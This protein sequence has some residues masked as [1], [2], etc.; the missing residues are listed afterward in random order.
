MFLT[1]SSKCKIIVQCFR[2]KTIASIMKLKSHFTII[3]IVFLFSVGFCADS[4]AKEI[5]RIVIDD[6]ELPVTAA[7]FTTGIG[8]MP[9][10]Q[11]ISDDQKKEMGK[12]AAVLDGFRNLLRAIQGAKKYITKENNTT[13]EIEG[14]LKEVEV[15][16]TR[17]L[18]NGMVEV[19]MKTFLKVYNI[20]IV[21]DNSILGKLMGKSTPALNGIDILE[22][23]DTKETFS[24]GEVII[25]D[26][27]TK[28]FD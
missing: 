17:Y 6:G 1:Y 8:E 18:K 3:F 11:N 25:Q 24:D 12:R 20:S 4:A 19:D 2:Y 23:D 14:Y 28:D 7:V 13:F 10:N 16:E 9:E 15:L 21:D 5:P 27:E 22:V 26:I